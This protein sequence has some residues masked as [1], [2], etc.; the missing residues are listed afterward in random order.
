[1]AGGKLDPR[2][3]IAGRE[4]VLSDSSGASVGG[5]AGWESGLFDR[6]SWNEAQVRAL[7]T[8]DWWSGLQGYYDIICRV[9]Y[10]NLRA[11]TSVGSRT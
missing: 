8:P 1:M 10:T 4:T 2:C 7:V 5:D 11:V 9:I 6:G 3:A